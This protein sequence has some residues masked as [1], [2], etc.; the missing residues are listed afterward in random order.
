MSNGVEYRGEDE[1]LSYDDD[2]S[3]G[4]QLLQS[5][6]ASSGRDIRLTPTAK[7]MQ[8][9]SHHDPHD[10]DADTR[11][12]IFATARNRLIFA[13]YTF[14]FAII[15]VSGGSVGSLVYVARFNVS[16]LWIE[17]AQQIASIT[18][19]IS[20]IA[21]GA[22]SDG[23]KSKYGRRKPVVF[24]GCAC[25][26]SS[27]IFLVFPWSH[28]QQFLA[29]WYFIFNQLFII[30][31]TFSSNSL[32]SWVLE[33]SA[34]QDDFNNLRSVPINVGNILGTLVGGI[35][36]FSG[37]FNIL[38]PVMIVGGSI[39]LSLLLYF[40]PSKSNHSTHRIRRSDSAHH[41]TGAG[42]GT[43]N[44]MESADGSNK[45]PPFIPSF[46]SCMRTKEF[47]R[48]YI[49]EILISLSF[50]IGGAYCGTYFLISG[51]FSTNM[52]FTTYMVY[53]AICGITLG[54]LANIL[55]GYLAKRMDKLKLYLHLT[56]CI[57]VLGVLGFMASFA[58]HYSLFAV[59]EM[60][61]LAAGYMTGLLEAFLVRDLIVYDTLITGLNRESMY[62]VALSVPENIVTSL[63]AILPSIIM[64]TTGIL[65][66]Y[67]YICM[68]LC[69][70]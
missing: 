7:S 60:L 33:S 18:S 16:S 14:F 65:P 11:K 31:L 9:E 32:S 30:G 63:L 58:K 53:L 41:S 64:F 38:V 67:T 25:I 19:V 6:H 1:Q 8:D 5:Q 50:R 68:F 12:E 48:I 49:N 51:Y 10:N 24:I 54:M 61:L 70:D 26:L 52:E 55:A 47:R 66:T 37:S 15:G 23:I 34:D 36:T 42:A 56:I 29:F 21:V 4:L 17:T 57:A 27:T 3:G 40:V 46:R 43:N 69:V 45:L 39:S 35:G 13:L 62:Q 59:Y 44:V 22:I 20:M 28:D 2:A